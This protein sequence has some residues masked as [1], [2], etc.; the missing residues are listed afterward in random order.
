LKVILA[1]TFRM[2]APAER[3]W[4]LLEQV[5]R[6][7]GCMPGASITERT[8]DRHY[9]GTVAVKFGPVSLSFRGEIEV[10]TLE[11][12]SRTLRLVGKGT[13]TTGGSGASMDLT[14]RVEPLDAGSS[15]LV[16]NAEVGLNGKAATF[17][18]RMAEAVA[19]QVLSQF[20]ANFA[21]ALQASSPS[22]AATPTQS[23]SGSGELN[24]AALLWAALRGWLRSLFGGRRAA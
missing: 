13:D 2:P 21:A 14:A 15:N 8:D 3:T 18:G 6:V 17:G 19:E 16:G 11:P 23:A 4:S 10:L 20:A 5:E 9:R 22:S 1:K 12:A 24:A 7:A